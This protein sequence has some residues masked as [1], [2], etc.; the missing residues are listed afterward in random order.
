MRIMQNNMVCSFH[1][2]QSIFSVLAN[3]CPIYIVCYYIGTIL[4]LV[5]DSSITILYYDFEPACVWLFLASSYATAC[6]LS[7][8]MLIYFSLEDIQIIGFTDA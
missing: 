6:T 7:P 5:E 8:K 4:G 1:L 2:T 3:R